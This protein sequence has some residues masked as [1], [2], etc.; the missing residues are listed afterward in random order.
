MRH[1]ECYPKG[2]NVAYIR[3]NVHVLA[4]DVDLNGFV[5]ASHLP[6]NFRRNMGINLGDVVPDFKAETSHGDIQWHS[7][8]DGSWAILFSHPGDFTPVCTTELGTT[9]ACNLDFSRCHG[10]THLT[11]SLLNRPSREAT[12]RVLRARD[13]VSGAK[14]QRHRVTQS[15]SAHVSGL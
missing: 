8:I 1:L 3:S 5:A 2:N 15:V 11:Q 14:L 9:A 6:L 13:Q 4:R 10:C 12:E 7:Y